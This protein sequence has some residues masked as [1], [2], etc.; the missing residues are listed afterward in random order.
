MLLSGSLFV[1]V[2]LRARI[3]PPSLPQTPTASAPAR[4]I[5]LA[6]YLLTVPAS[7]IST[8]S[9]IAASVTRRPS[10]KRG[11]DRQPLQHGVD[12][13][14]AAMHHDGVDADLLQQRDVAG[15]LLGQG[16][17]AHGVAAVFHHDGGAGIAAQERQRLRQDART[18]GSGGEIGHGGGGGFVHGGGV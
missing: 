6:T 10:T 7:T 8:T 16:F 11:L 4:V 12:L 14:P 1:R 5:R 13:R 3:S 17:L 18:F 9:T 2:S 15:E